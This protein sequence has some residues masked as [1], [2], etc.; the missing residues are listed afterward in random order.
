MLVQTSQTTA[1]LNLLFFYPISFMQS[2][3]HYSFNVDDLSVARDF[4]T[5][6][7]GCKEGRS[8]P[9]WVDFDFFGHQ[10]SLHLGVPLK[11]ANTGMVGDKK[12]PMPHFGLV[13]LVPEWKKIAQKLK[14]QSVEFII[15]P[16]LRFEGEPAEQWTMFFLDPFGNPIEIKGFKSFNDIF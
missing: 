9:S 7:L 6:I 2:L 3:F 5:R 11:T 1:T 12:V 16:H 14:D 4:Y 8:A 15:Q 13:T 10:I